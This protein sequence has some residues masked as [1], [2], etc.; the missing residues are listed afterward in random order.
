MNLFCALEMFFGGKD[1]KTIMG[2]K[3]KVLSFGFLLVFI[4]KAFPF[5]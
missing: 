1:G 3:T 5:I 4:S 2:A